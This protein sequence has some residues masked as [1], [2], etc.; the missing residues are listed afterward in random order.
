MAIP[1]HSVLYSAIGQA[2]TRWALNAYSTITAIG[3]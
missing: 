3:I 2:W 1:N